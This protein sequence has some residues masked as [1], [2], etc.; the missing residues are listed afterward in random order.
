MKVIE[1]QLVKAGCVLIEGLIRQFEGS[2][3]MLEQAIRNI[4]ES[5]WNESDA[6]WT[7][8][9][10]AY[11]SVEGTD[12]LSRIG[13]KDFTWLNKI[14]LTWDQID[15]SK[16]EFVTKILPRIT[17]EFVLDYFKEVRTSTIDRLNSLTDEN[18]TDIEVCGWS[19]GLFNTVLER[20]IYLLRHQHQHCGELALALRTWACDRLEWVAF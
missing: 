6:G 16:N 18:L 15:F 17:K 12:A 8:S 14:G 3:K 1:V 13:Q 10:V 5:K 7:Y 4:P 9:W 20:L 2:F 19:E 11:H